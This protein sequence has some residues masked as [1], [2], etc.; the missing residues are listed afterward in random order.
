ME[1]VIANSNLTISAWDEDL[2]IGIAPSVT[3]FHYACSLSDFAVHQSYQ[4]SG[5]GKRLQSLT[6]VGF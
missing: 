3:D 4:R 2:L 1:R 6:V 5:V